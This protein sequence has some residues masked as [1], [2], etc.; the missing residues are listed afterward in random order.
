MKTFIFKDSTWTDIPKED[1]PAFYYR[2]NFESTLVCLNRVFGYTIFYIPK[3][4]E[5]EVL[6]NLYNFNDAK[7]FAEN[8]ERS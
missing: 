2:R 7:R 5:E 6:G 4:G 3:T 1:N 8:Y